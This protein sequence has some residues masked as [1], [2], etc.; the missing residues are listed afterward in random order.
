LNVARQYRLVLFVKVFLG[1]R[2]NFGSDDGTS[3]KEVVWDI[4]CF[5]PITPVVAARG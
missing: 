5:I 1:S 3:I 2:E 4:S